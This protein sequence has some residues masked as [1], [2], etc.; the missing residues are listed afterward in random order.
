MP[1]AAGA[2]KTRV[3]EKQPPSASNPQATRPNQPSLATPRD[4]VLR[5]QKTIGNRAV[6]RLIESG[7]LDGP[8]ERTPSHLAQRANR[9]S[10]EVQRQG[11]TGRSSGRQRQLTDS[12]I[13]TA[14][15][16][17]SRLYQGKSIQIIG[18]SMWMPGA[19]SFTRRLILQIAKAQA[20]WHIRVDG[21]VG[22]G[23]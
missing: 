3:E 7:A 22:P 5:L 1:T 19:S 8:G 20:R 13:Q 21:Q 15:R 17:N 10:A 18:H 2:K 6:A 23:G 4:Q 16:F 9:S 12:E 11:Q 14:I